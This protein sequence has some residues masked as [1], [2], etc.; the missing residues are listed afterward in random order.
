MIIDWSDE[1]QSFVVEI[2]EQQLRQHKR[3]YLLYA[4][5]EHGGQR[6]AI[7]SIVK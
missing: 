5:S 4:F 3:R 1:D 7:Y 6:A 2:P